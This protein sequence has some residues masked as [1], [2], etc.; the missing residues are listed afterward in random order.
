MSAPL[1]ALGKLAGLQDAELTQQVDTGAGGNLAIQFVL[2]DLLRH[3]QAL[4]AAAQPSG[5]SEF[6][7][8]LDLAQAAYGE[9]VGL[10]VGRADGFLDGTHD[11]D[12]SLR[13]VLRHAIA[14]ELRYGAQIEY[15]ALRR[16]EEPLGIPNDRLPCDR[17]SPPE[18]QFGRTRTADVGEMI[19]LVGV[20]RLATDERLA[21]ISDSALQRPSLW[22]T[23]Q[24]SVRMRL[25]QLS[26]HLTECVIQSE[27]CLAAEAQLEARRI[28]RYVCAARG[29]HERWS[30][31]VSRADLDAR[32]R[33]LAGVDAPST[34]RSANGRNI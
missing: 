22:G 17:L 28:L 24:I 23:T 3:E 14:V 5:R 11:G 30:H 33:Q 12:W 27:K 25:H 13:D 19:D 18:P 8:I 10:L 9:L 15:S 16:D 26:V 21:V 2:Y 4:A 34:V 32:Y 1:D 31:P 7:R 20:A 6:E 29:A